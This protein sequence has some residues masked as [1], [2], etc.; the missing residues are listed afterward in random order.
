MYLSFPNPRMVNVHD[1]KT[2]RVITSNSVPEH[3]ESGQVTG[4]DQF[5][6]YTAKRVFV[7]RKYR[8][9]PNFAQVQVRAK[10]V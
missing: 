9:S 10:N 3:I 4:E 1:D 8:G 5:V 7:F 2:G 6:I